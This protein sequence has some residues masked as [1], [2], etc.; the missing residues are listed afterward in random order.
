MDISVIF[1]VKT[2][3]WSNNK[4][5][6]KFSKVYAKINQSW[7]KIADYNNFTQQIVRNKVSITK[8]CHNNTLHTNPGHGEEDVQ[9][10]NSQKTIKVKQKALSPLAR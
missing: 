4:K 3:A 9:P 1:S 2:R 10:H 8:R 5:R 7:I 6:T